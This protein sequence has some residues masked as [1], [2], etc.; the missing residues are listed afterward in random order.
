MLNTKFH[1]IIISSVFAPGHCTM[2]ILGNILIF[3]HDT[4]M[5]LL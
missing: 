5:M 3:K 4:W 2:L 1:K